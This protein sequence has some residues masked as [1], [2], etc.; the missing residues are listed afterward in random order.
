MPDNIRSFPVPC[1]AGLITNVD[2]LTQA[3]SLPGSSILMLNMEPSV[4]GGYRRISGFTNSYGVVPGEDGTDV[5]G[6]AVFNKLN[7]GIFAC[8]KPASGNNYFHRWDD[9]TEDWIT[10]TT[11]GS[12]TMT[13]VTR[14][15]FSKLNWGIPYLAMTDGVNPLALWDGTS[16]SQVTTGG[17][18]SA[19]KFSEDFANH[20]FIAGDTSEPQNLVFSAPLDPTDWDPANGAGV[21]NVGFDITAIKAFRDQLFI[22]GQSHIKKLVGTS[23]ADFRLQGITTKLGCIA[24]DTVVEFNSDLIFLGPDGIRPISATE[25]IGDIELSSRSK[26]IQGFFES[27]YRNEPV[28]R[29]FIVVINQKSQFRLLFPTTNSLGLLGAVRTSVGNNTG[30]E[31]SQLVGLEANCA[32]SGYIDG[33]EVVIHGDGSGQVHKQEVGDNFNGTPITSV[34]KTPYLHMD[35]PVVR[36]VYHTVHT[37]LKAEGLASIFMGVDYDYGNSDILKPSDYFFDL[38]RDASRFGTATFDSTD[39]FDGNPSPFRKTNVQGSGNSISLTYVTT[40]DQPS[41]TIQAFNIS[42]ELADRR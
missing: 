39:I 28:E 16:Y 31:Y 4:E 42:Y 26:N 40:E 18:L 10:P 21:I 37:Y 1:Q 29:S 25:R 12:P 34:F 5:L 32:D 36:K 22:F 41:H 24:P 27:Y 17:V 11:S 20:L 9:S 33:Y 23:F 7:D 2:P 14:V 3:G 8:R 30:F 35:D 6:V 15:R 13:G 38:S 19:P